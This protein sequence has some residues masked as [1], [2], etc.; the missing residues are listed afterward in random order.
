M[1]R[2]R[3]RFAALAALSALGWS[4]APLA[5]QDTTGSGP[6]EAGETAV[7]RVSRLARPLL[8]ANLRQC[9]R[10]RWDFGFNAHRDRKPGA[11]PAPATGPAEPAGF[12]VI[13]VIPQSPAARAGLRVGDR[14]VAV[15]GNDWA[16]AGFATAFLMADQ[17]S[18]LAR[19]LTLQVERDGAP[20]TLAV[21]GE[22]A[23]AIPVRLVAQAKPNASAGSGMAFINSGLEEALPQDDQLAAV[24]AHELAHVMLGHSRDKA[25]ST[26]RAAMERDADALGVRLALRA[27]FDPSAAA[28]AIEIVGARARGPISRL[29]GLYGDHM[30]T[31]QRKSF[32][33]EQAIAARQEQLAETVSGVAAGQR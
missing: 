4:G 17:A 31:P 20:V 14:L 22:R 10:Q 33:L 21:T 25:D 7:A 19:D 24:I 32:L 9:P 26:T 8:L 28:R 27:G 1:L 29:L 30:P 13:V 15:N 23:C 11:E 18:P 16:S 5:A 12:R 6:T 3:V 2:W